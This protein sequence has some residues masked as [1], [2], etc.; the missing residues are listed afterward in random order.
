MIKDINLRTSSQDDIINCF[1]NP[2]CSK[3]IAMIDKI[4]KEI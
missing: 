3:C 1:E 4:W 2:P